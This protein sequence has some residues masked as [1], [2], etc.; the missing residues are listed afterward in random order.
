MGTFF[1]SLYQSCKVSRASSLITWQGFYKVKEDKNPL[2]CTPYGRSVQRP[3]C[4][5]AIGQSPMTG[6][7]GWH[8]TRRRRHSIL[9]VFQSSQV[10]TVKTHSNC[11][12]TWNIWTSDLR[13]KRLRIITMLATQHPQGG[14]PGN[15]KSGHPT[16]PRGARVMAP[17]G[18]LLPGVRGEPHSMCAELCSQDPWLPA[19]W[20]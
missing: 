15:S 3:R 14:D 19:R 12:V 11:S 2:T 1:S 16:R 10:T 13:A 9:V 20:W 4:C 8:Q 7:Q 6:H 5:N 17:P 18:C